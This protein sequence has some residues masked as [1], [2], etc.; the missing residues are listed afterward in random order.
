MPKGIGVYI[1]LE[2][3]KNDIKKVSIELCY[4]AKELSDK[5]SNSF[6]FGIILTNIK[7]FN[8]S[9]IKKKLDLMPFKKIIIV[10][11][12]KL[13]YYST[14]I[15]TQIIYE[16]IRKE[17]PEIFLIGATSLGRDLAPR[18]SV[19]L[20]TGLTADCTRLEIDEDKKLAAVRPTFGG[21]LMATILTKTY[22]QMASVRANVFKIPNEYYLESENKES[23][24][25]DYMDYDFSE[26]KERVKIRSIKNR[27]KTDSDELLEAKV[28]ISIGG[29]VKDEDVFEKIKE[30]ALLA[31][32]KIGV[33]RSAVEKGYLSSEYQIGQ[34]GKTIAPK[35]YIA[36][37][38]SGANQHIVGIE[39][40][41]RIITI[42]IDKEAPIF[43]ISDI[44]IVKDVSK[45]VDYLIKNIKESKNI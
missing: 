1:E 30:F 14:E 32:C 5:L 9:T 24:E 43:N 16:I 8:E 35:L 10:N 11:N 34:T 2:Q 44:G 12:E 17:D 33:S 23:Q 37:G 45:I 4:K 39:N 3:E 42:N 27:E 13:R 41:E 28:V 25:Y 31:N 38:I 19:K 21:K 20:K 7:D 26:I 29:G 22:P 40:S 18:L 36:L 15:Y 6:V